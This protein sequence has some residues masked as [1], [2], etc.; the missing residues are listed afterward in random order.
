MNILQGNKFPRPTLSPQVII[1]C[2]AGGD[3]FGGDPSDVYAF[4]NSH[5]IPD[6]TCQQYKAK[7][8]ANESCSAEQVCKTCNPPVPSTGENGQDGC[9]ATKPTLYWVSEFGSVSGADDMKR[10]IFQRGPISCGVQATKKFEAYTSGIFSEFILFPEINHEI[11]VVGWG[12]SDSGE[13]Y[14]IGRNSW[15]TAWG[16]NGYFYIKMHDENLAIETDCSW[17]VPS[18]TKP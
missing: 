4:G 6:D 3:C 9:Y 15:G 7:D 1:N 17:G 8:P 13:E 2:H 16:Q 14:W 11:A 12:V 5:G 10:E 18:L